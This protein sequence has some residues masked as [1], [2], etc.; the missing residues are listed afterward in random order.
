MNVKIGNEAAQFHF[1]KYINR[2]LFAVWVLCNANIVKLLRNRNA[3]ICQGDV[4]GGRREM[5]R[6]LS[7]L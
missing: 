7:G 3:Y 2:I 4:R 6:A 5:M 1:C